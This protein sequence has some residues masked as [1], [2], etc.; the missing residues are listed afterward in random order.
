MNNEAY[1]SCRRCK[2]TDFVQ[3][4]MKKEKTLF[5]SNKGICKPCHSNYNTMSE[6]WLKAEK[7][8]DNSLTCDDC[9]N[10]FSKYQTGS[11]NRNNF[12]KLRVYC[13]F[14]KSENI[15]RFY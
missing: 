12:R 6:R 10:I 1:F 13:P 7:N 14:C 9:D 3:V 15:N 8:P 4:Q 2:K 5:I 11:S